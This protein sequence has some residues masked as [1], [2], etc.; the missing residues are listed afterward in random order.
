MPPNN[1]PAPNR[2]PRFP[3]GGLGVFGHLCLR[4]TS[5][6]AAVGEAQTLGGARFAMSTKR[7][8]TIEWS[9]LG[10]GICIAV[11]SQKIVFPGLESLLGIEKIVGKQNVAYLAD[12]GYAY[13]NPG[14]MVRWIASVAVVGILLAATGSIVLFRTRSMRLE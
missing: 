12:G 5:L 9:L 7:K 10:I 2:R 4:S 6:P 3:L 11:F 14:A 8:R 1:A 13:T